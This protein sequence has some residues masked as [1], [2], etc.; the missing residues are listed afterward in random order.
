MRLATAIAEAKR[1]TSVTVAPQMLCRQ[2]S[3]VLW[4]PL[5]SCV[6]VPP[7]ATSASPIHCLLPAERLDLHVSSSH[8]SNP[9]LKP[10][11]VSQGLTSYTQ[12]DAHALS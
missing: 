5:P 4:H 10:F 9:G 1:L 12:V 7:L 11:L 3:S 8:N 2:A 6:L